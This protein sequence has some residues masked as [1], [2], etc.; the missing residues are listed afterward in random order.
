MIVFI[1]NPNYIN[2]IQCHFNNIPISIFNLSS[3]YSGYTNITDLMKVATINNTGEPLPVFVESVNFDVQYANAVLNDP[4]LFSELMMIMSASFEGNIVVILIQRD[5]YRDAIME[6]LIKLI[7][8]RYGYNCW[9]IEDLSDI[10]CLKESKYT[11]FG[12]YNLDNDINTYD[13][14]YSTESRI[15]KEF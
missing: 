5:F 11:P 10:Y 8:Q 9:I 13:K 14:S 7:Q 3:L 12:L 4:K 2:E 15:S 1:D 6:S